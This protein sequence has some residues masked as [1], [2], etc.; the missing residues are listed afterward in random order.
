LKSE[1][2]SRIRYGVNQLKDVGDLKGCGDG[3]S[4]TLATDKGIEVERWGPLTAE[5]TVI[6]TPAQESCCLLHLHLTTTGTWLISPAQGYGFQKLKGIRWC[7]PGCE[8][9][10]QFRHSALVDA[11]PCPW[12]DG[13]AAQLPGLEALNQARPINR[14]RFG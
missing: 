1:T 5:Q 8:S 4:L 11:F 13:A 6:D 14:G 7:N 9:G 3:L 12:L 2:P 10:Q